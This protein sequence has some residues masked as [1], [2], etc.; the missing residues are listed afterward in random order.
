MGWGTFRAVRLSWT[1]SDTH[2]AAATAAGQLPAALVLWTAA[3][4]GEDDYGIPP[5]TLAWFFPLLLAPLWVPLTGLLQAAL[6]SRPAGS[7]AALATLKGHRPA[8]AWY[9]GAT[10]VMSALWAALATWRLAAPFLPTAATLTALG[11]LPTLAVLAVRRRGRG[12]GR[13]QGRE[14]D[15]DRDRRPWS[16]WGVW[17]RSVPASI[18]LFAVALTGESV[19]ESAGLLP[20]Y[21]PPRLSADRLTGVWHGPRGA[22][23]RL[24]P[25]GGAE[26]K[27]VPAQRADGDRSAEQIYDVCTA[28][29]TWFL[30][31]E[32]RYDRLSGEGPGERDGAV[33]RLEGCGSDTYWVIGGTTDSPEL[34]VLFGDP[35]AGDVRILRPF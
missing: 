34:F 14:R 2:V 16:A 10:G 13:S 4:S 23:L 30:D 6:L 15:R 1:P 21:D 28:T 20:E 12:R 17:W 7:L 24:S 35:D 29:G 9:L 26:A 33:V 11:T 22:E 27:S 25:G 31:T 5:N 8:W 3:F 18:A 19:A 32:G